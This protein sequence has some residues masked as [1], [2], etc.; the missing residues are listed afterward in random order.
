MTAARPPVHGRA[1]L[2]RALGLGEDADDLEQVVEV[3]GL[4]DVEA[5][6]LLDGLGVRPVGDGDAGVAVADAPWSRGS[7]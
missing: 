7:G 3:V 6:E 4:D 1:D 2:D 5:G